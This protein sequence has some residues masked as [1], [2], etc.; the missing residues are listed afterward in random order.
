MKVFSFLLAL[1][2]NIQTVSA[3]DPLVIIQEGTALAVKAAVN[4][5]QKEDPVRYF[6]LLPPI[7]ISKPDFPPSNGVDF[8]VT[9]GDTSNQVA[10]YIILAPA[11]A[12][13]SQLF[14][15]SSVRKYSLCKSSLESE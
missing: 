8:I 6:H 7:R 3:A 15:V 2:V 1:F 9:F 11:P 12:D 13:S 5:Y 4:E 10:Y 14:V